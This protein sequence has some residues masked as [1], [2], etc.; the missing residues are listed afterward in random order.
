MKTRNAAAA[1]KSRTPPARK[2]AAKTRTTPAPV[3]AEPAKEGPSTRGKQAKSTGVAT[4]EQPLPSIT[5]PP[6]E[7]EPEPQPAL[8]V[9]GNV[10]ETQVASE[11]KPA[12]KTKKVVKRVIRR[13]VG[14]HGINTNL[15]NVEGSTKNAE[16]E[17]EAVKE[18]TEVDDVEQ[19]PPVKDAESVRNYEISISEVGNL[20][21]NEEPRIESVGGDSVV[22]L[23][24]MN[25][26]ESTKQE[27]VDSFM[28][29]VTKSPEKQETATIESRPLEDQEVAAT[30][31]EK[32]EFV[33]Q[34]DEE[35][36]TSE[37]NV[38]TICQEDDTEDYANE[39]KTD[40]DGLLEEGDHEKIE[41]VEDMNDEEIRE[42][43]M[44]QG[45][46]VL[47]EDRTEL[48]AVAKE[49][50]LR[51]ELEIFVGGL[52]RSVTEEDLK[53]VFQNA[54][55]VVDV[56]LNK[57][58][59][60]NKNKGYAF[61]R[62]A[63]KE[64][65]TRVLSEMRNPVIR[66][67]RCGVAP[68][69]G[70]DSLFVG[71]I[72][73]T[74]TKEAIQHKLKDYGIEGVEKITLVADPKHEGLSRGFAFI[75]FS[76]HA[77]AMHAYKRLQKP[78][79]IFGHPERTV[80][81]AFAEP[82]REPDPEV[83]AQVKSVFV[84][85][86]PPQWD[87]GCVRDKFKSFGEIANVVLARDMATAKRKDFGFV[88]FTTHEAAV[89][90]IE[91]VN[92]MELV[93]GNSKVKVR[94][95]LSN[96]LPKTQAVKGGMAGGFRIARGS[97]GTT[98]RI[99]RGSGQGG[100][101]FSRPN[102]HYDRSFYPRGAGQSSGRGFVRPHDH[103]SPYGHGIRGRHNSEHEGRW[104][105]G[106]PH[107]DYIR[108]PP[109][110]QPNFDRIRHGGEPGRGAYDPLRREPFH[111]EVGFNRPYLGRHID[112]RY[113]Y[114]PSRGMKRPYSVRDQDQDPGYPEPIPQRPRFDYPDP[115]ASFHSNRY[116]D[117]FG[118]DSGRFQHNYHGPDYDRR[119]YP[120]FYGGH[121]PY[122]RGYY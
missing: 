30:G 83:M 114:D 35:M 44:E 52:D 17:G 54:G 33:A 15:L 108:G 78:D 87:E 73:N 100:H 91:S 18:S 122:G 12:T 120:P 41:G 43:D 19:K 109:P 77:E 101:A 14:S 27:V 119:A 70:H 2:A 67:K 20:G 58:P 28:E 48:N 53:R 106:G 26:E 1:E 112:D 31:K 8:A 6:P 62:F 60:T 98:S 9:V 68:N 80:K 117:D 104:G 97:G 84:D 74:W 89:A 85:G 32:E 51:K 86:L 21:V 45:E 25:V 72:C 107:Q 5:T 59:S 115:S 81:V 22:K 92:S 111:P 3:D 75:E 116:R 65:V 105:F 64:Q 13:T 63:T 118:P 94:A 90:C 56:R 39:E 10:V 76:C 55:E 103:D 29:S 99:G 46:E 88:D 42:N 71:N 47:E 82:L 102:F 110:N 113:F 61:V 50:K 34:P 36:K 40:F 7:P 11:I 38:G 69:E 96:P 24:M 37:D 4:T 49:N 79:A 57:D 93:D 121:R 16:V 66:G 95:R 23:D